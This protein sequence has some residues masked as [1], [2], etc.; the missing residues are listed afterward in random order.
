MVKFLSKLQFNNGKGELQN[1]ILSNSSFLIFFAR[2]GRAQDKTFT[3]GT[4]DYLLP[5]PRY[6]TQSFFGGHLEDVFQ[7]QDASRDCYSNVI[8]YYCRM[9]F[10]VMYT[11]ITLHHI[12]SHYMTWHDITLHYIIALHTYLLTYIHIYIHTYIHACIHTYMHACI[13]TY[14]RTYV[15]T[16]VHTYIHTYIHNIDICITYSTKKYTVYRFT[17]VLIKRDALYSRHFTPYIIL[18]LPFSSFACVSGLEYAWIFV[19]SCAANISTA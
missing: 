18:S 6:P 7:C 16:Y 10:H 13:H 3:A 12:T 9:M 2:G 1:H 4:A 8:L 11:N 19:F 17:Y 15:R 14:I 5:C